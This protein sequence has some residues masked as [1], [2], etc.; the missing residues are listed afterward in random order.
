MEGVVR[1][2]WRELIL[3][4]GKNGVVRVN[5]IDY[6]ICILQVSGERPL[7]RE[8][9]VEDA[10]RHRNPDNDLPV[11]FEEKHTSYYQALQL[12]EEA[13]RFVDVLR[14]GDFDYVIHLV[15]IRRRIEARVGEYPEAI[16]IDGG[17]P[18]QA[19]RGDS[20]MAQAFAVAGLPAD[21]EMIIDGTEGVD[22][23]FPG[24]L[25]FKALPRRWISVTAPVCSTLRVSIRPA[26]LVR[27]VAITR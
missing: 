25:P 5:R 21:G 22:D 6:E 15:S 4:K 20:A 11:V 18:L 16:F 26:F 17:Q 1:G 14:R 2:A 9:W 10:D 23:V 13:E 27:C 3:E 24:F 12:P 7:C 8:I 19:A